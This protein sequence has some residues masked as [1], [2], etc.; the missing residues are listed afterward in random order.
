MTSKRKCC[1]V[2][3]SLV[4]AQRIRSLPGVTPFEKLVKSL[5]DQPIG[6]NSRLDFN[7]VKTKL[8][9][10]ALSYFHGYSLNSFPLNISRAELLALINLSKNKNNVILRP[11][12]GNGV[13]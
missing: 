9:E 1:P 10:I 7:L 11:D 5:K 4:S 12:K 8:K 2:V 6:S 13:L 3:L